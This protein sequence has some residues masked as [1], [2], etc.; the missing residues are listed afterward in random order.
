MKKEQNGRRDGRLMVGS[1]T[2]FLFNII[3][4]VRTLVILETQDI[5]P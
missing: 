1:L 5:R 3:Y 2:V 4:I